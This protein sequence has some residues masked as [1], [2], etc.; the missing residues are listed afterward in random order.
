MYFFC[1]SVDQLPGGR[2]TVLQVMRL[3]DDHQV[4]FLGGDGFGVLGA[5][6]RGQGSDDARVVFPGARTQTAKRRIVAGDKISQAELDRQLLRPL[7]HQAR[8]GQNEDP[9][10]HLA[11]QVFL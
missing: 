11:Q 3:V 5:T 8:R 2:R 9:R 10:H 4:V 7:F 1:N 6:G